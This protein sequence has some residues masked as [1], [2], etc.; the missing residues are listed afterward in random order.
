MQKDED[1][2]NIKNLW[3]KKDGTIYQNDVRPLVQDLDELPLPDRSIYYDRYEFMRNMSLKRFITGRGCPFSCTFCHIKAR[4]ELNRGK[5]NFVRSYSPQRVVLEIATVKDKYPIKTIHFSDDLFGLNEKWTLEFL[6][7]Y[8]RE[9][10]LPFSCNVRVD[11]ISEDIA[12][13]LKEA[14]C[15]GVVFGIETGNEKIRNNLLGKKL[16]NADIFSG[17]SLLKA[18]GIRFLTNNMLG[19]PGETLDNAIETVMLNRK[20]SADFAR[21]S[22]LWPYPNLP[23]TLH[24]EQAGFLKEHLTIENFRQNPKEPL[25]KSPFNNEFRNIDA[26]FA[27]LVKFPIPESIIRLLVRIPHNWFYALIGRMQRY[28]EL[29]FF[30]IGLRSAI[31]YY[32]HTFKFVK[33]LG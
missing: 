16:S 9:I 23:I 14:G 19:L 21:T 26:L 24:A 1:I 7:L 29:R 32:F 31:S 8:K 18:N 11:Y 5:G 17:A 28:Q 30:K 2:T 33:D 4:R 25:L 27:I 15:H 3:V 13:A 10:P 12:K 6:R 22:I 20:I